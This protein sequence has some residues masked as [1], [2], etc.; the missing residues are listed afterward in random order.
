MMGVNH[1]H[2]DHISDLP[3]VLWGGRMVGQE[4]LSIVGPSGA[5]LFELLSLWEGHSRERGADALVAADLLLNATHDR[6]SKPWVETRTG[7]ALSFPFTG[8]TRAMIGGFIRCGSAP[9]VGN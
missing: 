7:R 2:P 8:T 4:P 1:L 9:P 5:T 3:A 6:A